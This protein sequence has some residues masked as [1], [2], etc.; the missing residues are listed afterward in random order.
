MVPIKLNFG[1]TDI[2]LSPRLAL[3][4]KKVWSLTIGNLI[5]YLSYV[6][7][8]FLAYEISYHDISKSVTDLGLFPVLLRKDLSILSWF[9]Y[10]TGIIL[11]IVSYLFWSTI[12]S[13]ITLSQ[14]KGNYSFPIIDGIKFSIQNWKS[15]ILSPLTILILITLLF[16]IGISL[17]L[18]TN[19]PILGPISFSI[20]IPV[21]F[22]GALFILYSLF[23]FLSSFLYTP[24]IVSC[25]EED[26]IG[27][28][29]QSYSITWSQPWR[30]IF[31]NIISLILMT[32]G[33]EN[34]ST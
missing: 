6:T 26:V 20:L 21:Y 3:S 11:W 30:I 8:S 7:F 31:Y 12:T 5:G 32:L 15:I 23:C 2:F 10:V 4:G 19:I 27:T 16:I 1:I 13:R 17:S 29:F 18:S 34:P 24:S 14:L 9:V 28:V 22:L 33:F 25:Y